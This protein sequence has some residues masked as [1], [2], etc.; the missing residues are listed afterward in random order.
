MTGGGPEA[1]GAA[2][3]HLWSVRT[4]RS[5]ANQESGSH[6]GAIDTINIGEPYIHG[7]GGHAMPAASAIGRG[8]IRC[9]PPLE[10]E[11]GKRSRS[12]RVY[13][14]NYATFIL[15]FRLTLLKPA[16]LSPLSVTSS[17]VESIVSV[18]PVDQEMRGTRFPG[19]FLCST[20]CRQTFTGC[21]QSSIASAVLVVPEPAYL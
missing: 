11:R 13:R 1:A 3:A 14:S 19:Y 20:H 7:A 18:V 5:L 21:P 10:I 15:V 17:L 12:R 8:L 16:T 2:Y 6:L 9:L 4:D